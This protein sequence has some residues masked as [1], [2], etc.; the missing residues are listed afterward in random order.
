MYGHISNCHIGWVCQSV[1]HRLKTL[2]IHVN[3]VA[4]ELE[5]LHTHTGG[6]V[7]CE[8]SLLRSPNF[9]HIIKQ[10]KRYNRSN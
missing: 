5:A 6:A 8:G 3:I 9:K 1:K 7:S 10:S 4:V 2:F